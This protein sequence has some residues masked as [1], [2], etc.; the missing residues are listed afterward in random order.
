MAFRLLRCRPKIS[1]GIYPTSV[2]TT[3]YHRSEARVPSVLGFGVG[4][5]PNLGWFV[6]VS[7]SRGLRSLAGPGMFPKV[8]P[9]FFAFLSSFTW[10]GLV[11]FSVDRLCVFSRSIRRPSL[12]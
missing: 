1:A 9:F 4:F 5:F 7:P 6:V 2:S 11:V 3:V 8:I 10:W 12:K